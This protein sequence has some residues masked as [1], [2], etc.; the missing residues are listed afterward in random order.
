[1]KRFLM[2]LVLFAPLGAWADVDC[3]ST[4]VT[5]ACT[6]RSHTHVVDGITFTWNYTCNGGDCQHGRLLDGTGWVRNPTGGNVT[7]VSVTPDD[8]ASGLEKNPGSS[9]K[10]SSF[11][12][13]LYSRAGSD[14]TYSATHDLSTQLPYQAAPDDGVY[15]KAKGFTGGECGYTSAVG[16][17]C[18]ESFDA[19]TVVRNV[20]N[21]GS[22]GRSTFR[23]GMAGSTKLWLTTADFDL[24]RLPRNSGISAGNYAQ[25]KAR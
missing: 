11:A 18:L 9:T 19:I 10:A 6:G 7:I 4:S 20:P 14:S 24:T 21:D 5:A 1:M 25:I 3:G 2:A 8:A 15:V 13:G 12:Q 16:S 22:L 17:D 23:P